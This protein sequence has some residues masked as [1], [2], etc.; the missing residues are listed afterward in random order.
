MGLKGLA[1][2]GKPLP[3]AEKKTRAGRRNGTDARQPETLFQSRGEVRLEIVFCGSKD[4][5]RIGFF[6]ERLR[7]IGN[8]ESS[9][10]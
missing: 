7:K 1:A 10:I 2:S 9:L 3:A 4:R 6:P 8:E 5:S